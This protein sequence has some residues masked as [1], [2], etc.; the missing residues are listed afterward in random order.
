MASLVLLA[1]LIGIVYYIALNSYLSPQTDL[2]DQLEDI[3]NDIK[4]NSKGTNV[5]EDDGVTKKR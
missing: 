5:P 4:K 1:L 2:V 3:L